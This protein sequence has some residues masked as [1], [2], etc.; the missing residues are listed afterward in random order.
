MRRK[1]LLILCSIILLPILTFQIYSYSKSLVY[2]ETL[3]PQIKAN[4]LK[5]LI[6]SL[7]RD[8]EGFAGNIHVAYIDPKHDGLWNKAEIKVLNSV[9][10]DDSVGPIEYIAIAEQKGKEWQLTSYKS[11]WKCKRDLLGLFWRITPCI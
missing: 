4:N 8:E 11:H 1:I 5:N 7:V 6:A 3:P 10:Y 2:K 9:V